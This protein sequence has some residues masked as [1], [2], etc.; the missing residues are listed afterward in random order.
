[1]RVTSR[2]STGGTSGPTPKMPRLHGRN[3]S[4]PLTLDAET[5]TCGS[6][7]VTFGKAASTNTDHCNNIPSPCT[8]H[9]V[10]V[11][12]ARQQNLQR[13]PARLHPSR[14]DQKH[15]NNGS[16]EFGSLLITLFSV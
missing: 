13:P 5:K 12:P 2:V 3:S 14:R 4:A 10:Y 7:H 9:L 6:G 8:E 1:M 16:Q 11:P 15:K